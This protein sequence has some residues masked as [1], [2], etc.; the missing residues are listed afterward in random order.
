MC[1]IIAPKKLYKGFYNILAA[2]SFDP[3]HDCTNLL[4]D[5]LKNDDP[6]T[7]I[8]FSRLVPILIQNLGSTKIPIC[9]ATF[10]CLKLYSS[11]IGGLPASQLKPNVVFENHYL[12][13]EGELSFIFLI[14]GLKP[15]HNLFNM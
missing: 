5:I 4:I 3:V 14:S 2:H 6:D 8:F 1:Q 9:T 11:K 13:I 12:G 10:N 7:E 15:C